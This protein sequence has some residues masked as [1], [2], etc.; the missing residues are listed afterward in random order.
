MYTK[1]CIILHVAHA[2]GLVNAVVARILLLEMAKI[3]T[4]YRLNPFV[5]NCNTVC[6]LA[7]RG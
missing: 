5:L 4:V 1:P 6:G 7:Q 3:R 2:R